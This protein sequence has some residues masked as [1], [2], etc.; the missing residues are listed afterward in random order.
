MWPLLPKAAQG[1]AADHGCQRNRRKHGCRGDAL[2][3]PGRGNAS[4]LP[5]GTSGNKNYMPLGGGPWARG[6]G[7]DFSEG[8]A[9]MGAFLVTQDRLK[10]GLRT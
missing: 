2:R 5:T 7:V 3:R 4:P 9:M 6:F 10:A 1:P 8:F